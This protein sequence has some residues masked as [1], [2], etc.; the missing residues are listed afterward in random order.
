MSRPTCEICAKYQG[1]IYCISGKDK[2]FPALF[3][4]ALRSGYALMHPNCRHEFI[5]VWLE[6]MDEKELAAEI[7]R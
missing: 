6:L 7:D 2:R 3:E 4:T 1:K 5:P